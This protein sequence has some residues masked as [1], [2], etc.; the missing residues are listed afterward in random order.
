M[1]HE[2]TLLAATAVLISRKQKKLRDG[3]WWSTSGSI[4]KARWR[5]C[6][7]L[8]L[9]PCYACLGPSNIWTATQRS[10]VC[11]KS[12]RVYLKKK[13]HDDGQQMASTSNGKRVQEM[14]Q[15]PTALGAAGRREGNTA[16]YALVP[17]HR[18]ALQLCVDRK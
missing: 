17:R 15:L 1:E 16:T 6:Q 2:I 4:V 10:G 3:M 9:E 11:N 18:C 5:N 12:I 7:L 14:R 8:R 13:R